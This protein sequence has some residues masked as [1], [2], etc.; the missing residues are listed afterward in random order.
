MWGLVAVAVLLGSLSLAAWK[1]CL[2]PQPRKTR[3]AVRR[4]VPSGKAPGRASPQ[5]APCAKDGRMS[6]DAPPVV[7]YELPRVR[8]GASTFLSRRAMERGVVKEDTGMKQVMSRGELW[9]STDLPRETAPRGAAPGG[10]VPT[11]SRGTPG[12]LSP[13][14]EPQQQHRASM[15]SLDVLSRPA[16]VPL[17][18]ALL[19]LGVCWQRQDVRMV[20]GRAPVA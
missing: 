12:G 6:P 1:L 18:L 14:T 9:V 4:C 2:S 16:F 10:P 17:D 8:A 19:L 13:R 11:S 3:S 20:P 15:V 5:P 7:R